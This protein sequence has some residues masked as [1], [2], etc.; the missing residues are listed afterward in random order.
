MTRLPKLCFSVYFR[1]SRFKSHK[2]KLQFDILWQE[3][4]ISPH[5]GYIVTLLFTVSGKVMPSTQSSF[6]FT[7]EAH[8]VSGLPVLLPDEKLSWL[9][10]RQFRSNH[11]YSQTVN[12]I[13]ISWRQQESNNSTEL[14]CFKSLSFKSSLCFLSKWLLQCLF[15]HGLSFCSFSVLY[16][17]VL[18]THSCF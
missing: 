4:D 9:C 8:H 6:L 11:S 5:N 17:V 16:S 3:W 12:K 7:W 18:L 13:L 14:L 1:H 2:S 15:S 10:L